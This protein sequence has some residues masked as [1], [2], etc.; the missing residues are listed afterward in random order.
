MSAATNKF[1]ASASRTALP[2]DPGEVSPSI[3]SRHA[4]G[5]G[6][7]TELRRYSAGND[8]PGPD[9]LQGYAVLLSGYVALG[10]VCAWAIRRQRRTVDPLPPLDI[11]SYAIATQHLSRLLS[12]DSVTA[13]VR[14]PFTRF[15]EAAGEGELNEEVRGTGL[16]HAVGELLTC[17]FCV[18]QWVA[19][20]LIT[21]RILL[22]QLTTAVVSLSVIARV[23]DYLQLLY[24]IGRD[25]QGG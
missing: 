19:T 22:P 20:G 24:G 3:A 8:G 17:P 15:K 2:P 23:S 18:S 12:K 7:T 10:G 4:D 13:V 21:G 16:R 9:V 5:H 6:L 11:L 14:A 25:G 1:A